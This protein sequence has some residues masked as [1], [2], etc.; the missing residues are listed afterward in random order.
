LIGL[1]TYVEKSKHGAW[2]EDAALVPMSYVSAVIRSGGSP[3][4]LPPQP[5]DPA[6]IVAG[7]AGLVV[8]GGADVDPALYGAER[9]P[10]TDRPRQERDAWEVALC[11]AALERDIPLLAI[12]RGLQL[13]NVALGGTLH[14]HVPDVV[15]NTDHR[16]QVGQMASNSMLIDPDSSL[17]AILG[18]QAMGLCHHHQAIDRV[19]GPLRV[20]ARAGDGTVEAV[21]IPGHSFA[22]GVQWH[23]EDN[24]DDDRIFEAFVAATRA[25][26][27]VQ[28]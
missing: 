3:V 6:D 15:G 20:V 19:G 23:P 9:G 12:C 1:S 5:S 28:L 11:H 16:V 21:E 14:Q 22:V 25:C 10:H 13:L 17:G 2:D 26:A 24:P 4:L 8:I 7:L 27:E 18:S